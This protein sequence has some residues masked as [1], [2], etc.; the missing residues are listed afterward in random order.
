MRWRDGRFDN[1]LACPVIELTIRDA[2]NLGCHGTAISTLDFLGIGV[3]EQL[4]LDSAIIE[5]FTLIKRNM[6][7]QLSLAHLDSPNSHWCNHTIAILHQV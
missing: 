2:R 3:G 5:I 4:P 1:L 6:K 7:M